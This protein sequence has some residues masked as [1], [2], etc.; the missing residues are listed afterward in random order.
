MTSS[1]N[2]WGGPSGDLFAEMVLERLVADGFTGE[3]VVTPWGAPGA[4]GLFS[5]DVR[6]PEPGV[7]CEVADWIDGVR[8]MDS[9][10][11][12]LTIE[13]ALQ[14]ISLRCRGWSPEQA[15]ATV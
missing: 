5:V 2:V 6:R 3:V 11:E 15:I 14:Y 8:V 1:K 10:A 13:Q 12:D 4:E 7:L 9:R